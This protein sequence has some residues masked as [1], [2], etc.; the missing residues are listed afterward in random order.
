M[1]MKNRFSKMKTSL[2]GAMC[3][4]STCGITYSCSDDYD[5]DET[6]P[7]FLGGSIYD[8]LKA[9]KFTTVVR[10]IDDLEYADVLSRTGSKTL[11]VAPDSAFDKFFLTTDWVDAT[12]Q[13][14][15]SYEQLTSAQKKLLLYNTMLNNADVLEMLPYSNGGGSLTM[16]RTTAAS[17]VDTVKFWLPNE[18]PDNK[19]IGVAEGETTTGD[20]RFW[21]AYRKP[22]RRGI[23]MA[24]DATHP[25][26]LHFIEDQMKERSVTHEDVSF[27]LGLK[28]DKVWQNGSAGGKRTYIYD[29]QVIEQ[30][31]TCLNG[32]FNVLDKVV[33]T[34]ANMAEVIRTNGS[35]NLFSQMLDRFSA[36]Y[37]SASLTEQYK[38]LHDI[39]N[40]SVFAKRYISSRSAGGAS[41][42]LTPDDKSLGTFPLLNFDPG[43]NEYAGNTSL[44]KEQDMAAM[45]VPSDEALRDYFLTGGGSAL[46]NRFATEKP[47]TAEN[48]SANLYQIPLNIVQAL[49]NNLMK[50]SFLETVPSKYE[51]IKNDAQDQM[52]PASDNNYSSLEKYKENF[53]KCLLANNGVVY[54]MNKVMTPADYASVIAPALYSDNTQIVNAVV[55]ADDNYIQDGYNNAPLQKYFST[56]LKAMQSHFTFFVPTDEALGLYGLIDPMTFAKS[57]TSRHRYWRFAYENT[58]NTV[59]PIRATAYTFS[60][61]KDPA[62]ED[63]PLSGATNVSLPNASLRT[64]TGLTKR[65]LLVDMIDQH[66]I[67]HDDGD[68][69][70]LEGMRGERSYYISRGGAPVYLRKKGAVE[71]DKLGLGMIVDGGFQLQVRQDAAKYPSIPECEVIEGYNM[72]AELNGYGNGYTF[73]LNRPMQ[74]TTKSVYNVLST[75]TEHFSEF[76]N[77]C[78]ETDF[79]QEVLTKVGFLNDKMTDQQRNDEQKKYRIFTTSGVHPVQGEKLVRFFNNYRYSIYA[80]TNAAIQE[81][82]SKGLMNVEDIESFVY[83]N[84]DDDG[85]LSEENQKKAQAMITML[86]N[87]VKYHFQD[88]MFFVDNVTHEGKYQTSCI[89]NV[90]NIYLSIGMKQTPGAMTLTD[91]DNQTVNVVQPYNLMARDADFDS[92]VTGTAYSINSSS[93]VSIHQV[94]KV[95]NFFDLKGGRYDSE[96]ETPAAAQKFVA[97]YRIRK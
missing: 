23:Y 16:R 39:G 2:L 28:G 56:Y 52:F 1:R 29:A 81:A 71:A 13:P 88:Q 58:G 4:L 79:P 12:G 96:W 93:Y 17:A 73:F 15:R 76:F 63:K 83:S 90:A 82:Y 65:Q 48:L 91:N 32:Y 69:S 43:W 70:D 46:L 87:F 30:D 57:A 34:P 55:R 45:F 68:P 6:M 31:V 60:Y 61:T 74:A 50:D 38:A 14:V 20:M 84:L 59:F 36:P 27:I 22:E 85:N 78:N 21:D 3:L 35:T 54:V 80:P 47:V 42:S 7:S 94:D 26:M 86:V 44:P 41:I 97:K 11:F 89:D 72:S 62:P 24:L 19:N 77:L 66:I 5:L 25:M 10:L 67:V 18:L 95:L 37:Y 8:E 51:T 53:D 92:P 49:I 64:T 75:D 9:R 40:D 33:V